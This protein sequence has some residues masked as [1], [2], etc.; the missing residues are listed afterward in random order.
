MS[1]AIIINPVAGARARSADAGDLVELARA[2]VRG[3]GRRAD[4]FVT[5]R[6]GHARELART[7]R[8]N[9]ATL[10]VAWGGDGTVNEVASALAFGDVP[11]GIVAEGSGNGLAHCLG[12]P[13]DPADALRAAVRLEPRA[14]DIGEI[15]GRIFVNLA[16]IG[17]DAHIASRFNTPG[18]PRRGLMG[19]ALLTMR[20]LADYECCRYR[21]LTPESAATVRA[22]LVVFANGTEFGNR[23]RIAPQARIDDG[24][25]DLVVVEEQ[26]RAR[27]IWN[28]P[29]VLVGAVER[30]PVWSSRLVQ[31][32]TVE[33]DRP[34]LFHV[35]GE[36]A[37]GGT[38][39]EVAVRPAA[40]KI[41]SR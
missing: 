29:R 8:R 12:I 14:I 6:P 26:S 7:A 34:M 27:T 11:L 21:I 16:G 2:V 9:G 25:L 28:L 1:V 40:L 36:P 10:V 41:C 31:R 35:D 4:V 18:N 20:G 13:E 38:R 37:Q 33:S 30:A 3:S 32:V 19:Y 22:L 39:L 5:E 24:A 23:I 15:E 17:F